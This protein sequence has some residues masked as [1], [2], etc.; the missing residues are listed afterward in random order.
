MSFISHNK[1]AAC[2]SGVLV[3]I[4]VMI[5]SVGA[6][7]VTAKAV[8]QKMPIAERAPY[9]AGVVEGVAFA[10]YLASGKKVE[11][12]DCVYDWFTGKPETLGTIIAA[13]DRYGDFT[14]G[15]IIWELV[16]KKCGE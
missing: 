9:I 12:L 13:F 3:I 11:A 15:A 7:D 6:T 1:Y 2:L 8:M 16:K 14:P 10:R 4:P 5:S